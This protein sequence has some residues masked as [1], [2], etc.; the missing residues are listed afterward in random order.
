MNITINITENEV[1]QL[2]IMTT[3]RIRRSFKGASPE[4]SPN[5]VGRIVLPSGE[6]VAF[7]SMEEMNRFQQQLDDDEADLE[8]EHARAAA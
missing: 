6:V 4:I 3:D 2:R 8:L 7:E 5:E 1:D